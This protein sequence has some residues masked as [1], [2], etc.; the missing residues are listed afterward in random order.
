MSSTHSNLTKL[1]IMMANYYREQLSENDI[2]FWLM[3]LGNYSFYEVLSAF[4][5][6]RKTNDRMP[7]ISNIIEIMRGSGEDRALAALI[8]VEKAM[9]RYGGYTTVVFDDPIIHAVISELG[10]WIRTCRQTENEFT[11]W[12]KDF[13]ERYQHHNRYGLPPD[14]PPK[15]LGILDEKNL[16]LGEKPRKPEIIGD[17]EKAIGWVSKMEKSVSPA[18]D[19]RQMS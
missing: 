7:K 4:E 13:R 15:L 9:E 2:A 14:L 12:R 5:T 6:W 8:K 3:D 1:L 11:W 18:L 19:A 16:P 17:Y 10:G